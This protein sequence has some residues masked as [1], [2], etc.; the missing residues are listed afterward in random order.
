MAVHDHADDASV[1]SLLG[2]LAEEYTQRLERGEQ[3]DVE[4]YASA[5]PELAAV[6]REVFPA[7]E[8][9]RP[10][11]PTKSAK[12]DPFDD[13]SGES[14]LRQLGDY[15]LIREI[16]R[17][18]MGVVYEAQQQSLRRRVALKV[19]P[20]AAVLDPRQ[21]ERFKNEAHAAATLHHT[22]IV[23]VFSLGCE[24]GVYY[25]A[26][27]FIEGH[28]LSM[29]IQELGRLKGKDVSQQGRPSQ[30]A[31]QVA[32][33]IASGHWA[34][35]AMNWNGSSNISCS[36]EPTALASNLT[37]DDNGSH[38]GNRAF[39]RAVANIGI[40]AAEALQ[41]AHDH[42]V[43]H[44]DVKPSNLLL[45]VKGHAW[46][47]DFGLAL[48]QA[49]TG[50]TTPGDLLGTVRYMSPEQALAG[51]VP[52]DHRTDIYSL[53][54]TLYEL[55]A[56]QPAFTGND[57][58]ELL[59]QI[60]FDDPRALRRVNG[61]IPRELET[62]VGKCM[63]KRPNDR[64]ATSQQIADDLR[65]FLEDKPILA[66]PPTLLDRAGKWSRRHRSL[67]LSSAAFLV[68][69]VIGLAASTVLVLH[70]RDVARHE[71]I[72]AEQNLRVARA[73]VDRMLRW[74][75]VQEMGNPTATPYLG[76]VR[77]ELLE[78]A[79]R[80]QLSLL[81]EKLDDPICWQ[82]AAEVYVQVGHI[83]S[84]LN[85]PD[86]AEASFRKGIEIFKKLAHDYPKT[87]N[88][89]DRHAMAQFELATALWR[90]GLS[91]RAVQ[92]V[93]AAIEE[94]DA[95]A[96]NA[97]DR[98]HYGQEMCRCRN[99]LGL[100]LRDRGEFESARNALRQ[101]AQCGTQLAREYPQDPQHRVELAR[102]HRNLADIELKM[103]RPDTARAS[104][105]QAVELQAELVA[106]FPNEAGYVAELTR[107]RRWWA[108]VQGLNPGSDPLVCLTNPGSEEAAPTEL[109][110]NAAQLAQGWSGLNSA[111]R[112]V[113][114]SK[115]SNPAYR[116]AVAAQGKLIAQ[117][118][119]RLEYRERL[120]AIH[121]EQGDTMRGAWEVA[122]AE[123]AYQS[124]L[125]TAA[126]MV[127]QSPDK[128]EYR[129]KLAYVL[130]S[131]QGLRAR[132]PIAELIVPSKQ[133]AKGVAVAVE[134]VQQMDPASFQDAPMPLLIYADFLVLAGQAE[135]SV[136]YIERAIKGD[137][138]TASYYKVLGI[139]QLQCGHPAEAKV[140][141]EKAI[142]RTQRP[143]TPL[144]QA[145]PDEWTAAYFLD[146]VTA[147][148]FVERWRGRAM[149]VGDLECLPWYYIGW[150][151]EMEGKPDQAR[152]AYL[153]SIEAGKRPKAHH[154]ANM[155]AYRLNLLNQR[156]PASNPAAG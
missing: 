119:D 59:R 80:F 16:G 112:R 154:S 61:E 25:Y 136:P 34:H 27:Q 89:A 121:M 138:K 60:A 127:V 73:N 58:N 54:A 110:V 117:Y 82:D 78:E 66:K 47:T 68:L 30:G 67:V 62:I 51:R 140:A 97:S 37:R 48:M 79:L 26:M 56:V 75:E 76:P 42:G 100:V 29:V 8:V 65:R 146:R 12:L 36:L 152:E 22:N 46:V 96:A 88:H 115:V 4:S 135:K 113:V 45:D 128:S 133:S 53:G 149:C 99:L 23:P 70:Q 150:R 130:K 92:P 44:R 63:A 33:S 142:N 148:Q 10:A 41:Y 35:D 39:F 90:A 31:S 14:E 151:M 52:I 81:P 104:Y 123:Q 147:E 145:G 102:T 91:N 55:L 122:E 137:G 120:L 116:Q 155:A 109:P 18:G 64:Y 98:P 57:R 132:D 153:K 143:D 87:G 139:A 103:N 20:F 111:I 40:Q 38:A 1:E 105:D 126:D 94:L 17:G 13:T 125:E 74:V 144:T 15:H 84:L 118:P 95:M 11:A 114:P 86:Q 93:R 21:L 141:F 124:A 72:R 24:R 32:E 50:L 131:I 2:E 156:V 28:P 101:A 83:K 69:A 106:S 9:M 49:Q 7:L 108:E 5:H 77:Q 134:R 19:L 6:I 129:V 43:V 3:P 71:Q 107:T 85:Q